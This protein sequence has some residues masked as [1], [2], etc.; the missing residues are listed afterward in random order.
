VGAAG[1]ASCPPHATTMSADIA[2][3]IVIDERRATVLIFKPPAPRVKGKANATHLSRRRIRRTRCACWT[4]RAFG[5]LDLR[6]RPGGASAG[7]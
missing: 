5:A 4:W 3:A 6:S 7:M 2:M 1:D